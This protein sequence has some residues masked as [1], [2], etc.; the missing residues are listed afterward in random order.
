MN[1]LTRLL[2]TLF[3]GYALIYV[4]TSMLEFF[5]IGFDTYGVYLFYIIA[6]M[7]F[8]SLLPDNRSN[9]FNKLNLS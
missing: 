2:Y 6:L 9:F 7:L 4:L 3:A 8:F 1:V 5:D